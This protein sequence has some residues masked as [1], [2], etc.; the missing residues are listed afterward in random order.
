MNIVK[1][2][3]K[4]CYQIELMFFYF[5]FTGNMNFNENLWKKK[6]VFT[7]PTYLFIETTRVCKF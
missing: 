3:Y 6:F 5:V 4:Q 2:T 7:P 1:S